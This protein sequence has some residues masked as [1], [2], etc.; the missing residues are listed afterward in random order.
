MD[1]WMNGGR[2]GWM[3]GCMDTRLAAW[4]KREE[5]GNAWVGGGVGGWVD[6]GILVSKRRKGRAMK[7]IL[8]EG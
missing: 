5:G 4:R 8:Q 1:G 6:N 2:D 3:Y 7:G